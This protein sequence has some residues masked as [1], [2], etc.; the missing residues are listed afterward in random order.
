MLFEAIKEVN[1]KL[2]IIGD[3]ELEEIC[4][5]FSNKMG[6]ERIELLGWQD[7]KAI[8][9]EMKKSD[10]LILPSKVMEMSGLAVMEAARFYLPSY[11]C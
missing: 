11:R 7:E 5:E 9:N 4:R 10:A 3:G 8:V 6:E 1:A 2:I